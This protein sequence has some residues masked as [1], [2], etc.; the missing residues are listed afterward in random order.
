M[1]RYYYFKD[2]N[3]APVVTVAL[4][5]IDNEYARGVAIC[6]PTENF[7]RKEGRKRSKERA[8]LAMVARSHFDQLTLAGPALKA[9]ARVVGCVHEFTAFCSMILFSG[10]DFHRGIYN[11]RLTPYEEYLLEDK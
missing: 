5:K 9:L 1:I 8:L 2:S 7:S 3:N 4:L 10:T 11:P 6:S